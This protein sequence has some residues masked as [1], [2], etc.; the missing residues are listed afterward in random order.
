MRKNA[1]SL[2]KA[3]L[4]LLLIVTLFAP[5]SSAADAVPKGLGVTV[6]ELVEIVEGNRD[7]SLPVDIRRKPTSVV[8]D[9]RNSTTVI[10]RAGVP[11]SAEADVPATAI[12][13]GVG[14]EPP[15]TEEALAER[16]RKSSQSVVDALWR[17]FSNMDGLQDW[18]AAT[19]Q[20][21]FT[22]KNS[23]AFAGIENGLR[24]GFVLALPS[25]F[26]IDT[27]VAC[28]LNSGSTL[29]RYRELV[30]EGTCPPNLGY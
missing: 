23:N 17:H 3:W 18:L 15:G 20:D 30:N 10:V 13:I 14:L 22:D 12:L 29:E 26:F 19:R 25:V 5:R 4:C 11:I 6:A 9:F 8:Y 1:R 21:A 27:L 24:M 28:E 2:T 7:Q 16:R